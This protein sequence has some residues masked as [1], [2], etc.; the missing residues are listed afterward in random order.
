MLPGDAELVSERTGVPWGGGRGGKSVKRF[1]WFDGLSSALYKNIHI[2]I[3]PVFQSLRPA[4]LNVREMCYRISDMGLCKVQ[5]GHTYTLDEFR[6]VQFA[7][8]EEVWRDHVKTL[9]RL[10]L[11]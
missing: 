4:L 3:S 9:I 7:Q 1:E 10:A 2:F 11:K 8:L 5:K 6:D